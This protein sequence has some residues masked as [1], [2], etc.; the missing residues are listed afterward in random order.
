[1]ALGMNDHVY[2]VHSLAGRL[3]R[4]TEGMDADQVAERTGLPVDVARAAMSGRMK[5]GDPVQLLG[6]LVRLG[7]RVDIEIAPPGLGGELLVLDAKSAVDP[8]AGEDQTLTPSPGMAD[9]HAEAVNDR[10]KL[11][12]HRLIARALSRDPGLVD[13]AMLVNETKVGD[14]VGE[15]REILAL[16]VSEIRRLITE[17]SERMTRLRLSSPFTTL[18][19]LTDERLRRRIWRS[20]KRA[21]SR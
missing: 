7:C 16:D 21:L 8:A 13:R 6:A 20:A 9:P 1:M 2:L 10:A 4:F 5:E 11:A 3:A 12:M 18:V 17:R 19:D 14:F 15:W